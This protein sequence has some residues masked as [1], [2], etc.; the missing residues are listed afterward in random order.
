[1]LSYD[2]CYHR[3]EIGLSNVRARAVR[4]FSVLH[5]ISVLIRQIQ[6]L[7]N[8]VCYREMQNDVLRLFI[9]LNQLKFI[10]FL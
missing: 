9:L 3:G 7:T 10:I 6:T 8:I 2:E 1:M 5:C 4:D